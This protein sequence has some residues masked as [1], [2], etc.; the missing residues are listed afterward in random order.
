MQ[1]VRL[2]L[3]LALGF[4]LLLLWNAW[5]QDYGQRPVAVEDTAQQEPAA[6]A[7]AATPDSDSSPTVPGAIP[8]SGTAA[9][10]TVRVVTDL[11]D[12][13][14]STQGGDI[15]RAQL[16]T[17]AQSNDDDTPYTLLARQP[18]LYYIVQSALQAD[19][20]QA[21][22][23]DAVYTAEAESYS[24]QPEQNTLVVPLVWEAEGVRV[25]KRYFF[26]RD[27]YVVRVEHEVQNTGSAAW[28]GFQ[29]A[30]LR[31]TAPQE[32]GGFLLGAQSYT[33]GVL[34]TPDDRY[35]K[36]D[37]DDMAKGTLQQDAEAGWIAMLQHYFLTA[38][39]PPEQG[40][41]R[42]F[43]RA[44]D[45]QYILG[46]S[47][48]WRTAEP[49]STV[50]YDARLYLGPKEQDRLAAV[51]TDLELTVDY[52]ILSFIAKPL[53]WLLDKIHDFIG[54]WGWS[55]VILTLLIKLVFFKLS[56]TSYR[57]MARMRKMQPK[58]Q[59]LK[60]RFGDDRQKLNQALMELYKKEKIN[61]LG[62]CLPILIQIP[63]FIALYWML[64]ESVELR[65]ADFMLWINDL[66]S[67]D[68]FYVLPI[69]MGLSMLLQQRLNPAPMDPVQQKIMTFLPIVFTAFFLLFPAGLVLYWVTNNVISIAQQWVITRRIEAGEE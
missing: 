44:V 37:F 46:M 7:P 59:Q 40:V 26:E 38:W 34:H 17:H 42:F 56:E 41:H 11:L 69:L 21:P 4:L 68:P 22:G 45:G 67:P 36:I 50:S 25:T 16:P 27:S 1:N 58:M 9:A 64:L 3:V 12:L 29:F 51:A 30:Q 18:G 31:R 54:N 57:S 62:G 48:P 20:A 2:F 39:V 28:R 55:I 32:R 35:N 61:P 52:G 49:G 8:G 63:V 14:I 10:T 19:N 47:S 65:H 5:Q 53:F 6:P 66:S 24:L 15:V 60:E 43:A 23:L 13:D 33:G